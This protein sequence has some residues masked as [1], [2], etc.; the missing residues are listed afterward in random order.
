M[1]LMFLL[2]GMCTKAKS[3]GQ[4]DHHY[5]RVLMRDRVGED[6]SPIHFPP[7]LIIAARKVL[8]HP[9]MLRVTSAASSLPT[10]P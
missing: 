8:C 10:A 6:I 4:E 5:R 1:I 9:L 2:S 7:V 3:K